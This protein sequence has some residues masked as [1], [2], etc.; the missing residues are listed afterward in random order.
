MPAENPPAARRDV[1]A[2]G[3]PG[4]SARNPPVEYFLNLFLNV[5]CMNYFQRK[6]SA[7]T[8]GE[9]FRS[10]SFIVFELLSDKNENN[11]T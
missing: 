1:P 10:L 9:G 4:K 2:G 11:W 7:E 6:S 3:P 5:I 8:I